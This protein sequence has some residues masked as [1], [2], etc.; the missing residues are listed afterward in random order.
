MDDDVSV[1]EQYLA[2]QTRLLTVQAIIAEDN[3]RWEQ[4]KIARRTYTIH[5]VTDEEAYL[6]R[7]SLGHW[8]DYDAD[9]PITVVITSAGGSVFAGFSMFDWTRKM[10][11]DGAK[12]NT[13]CIGYAASMGG[14]LLQM[15]VERTMT[16]NSHMMV[17]EASTFVQGGSSVSVLKDQTEFIKKLNERC[18]SVL[19]SRSSITAEEITNKSDRR[20]WWLTADEALTAGF[21]D[22]VE[23]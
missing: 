16:P 18:V 22:R 20:D 13:K 11:K 14:V 5:S 7:T 15:G 1:K 2:A 19:A 6:Y 21:I 9:L 10:I 8:L 12:I 17:H 4:V 23:F 3:W